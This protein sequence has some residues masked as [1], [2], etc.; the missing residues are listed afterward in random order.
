MLTDPAKAGAEATPPKQNEPTPQSPAKSGRLGRIIAF[1]ALGLVA[2]IIVAVAIFV[3]LPPPS[4]LTP[5]IV[6][7]VA[8]Q[9]GRELKVGTAS[10]GF[11]PDFVL[12]FENVALSNPPGMSG[13]DLLKADA[14]DVRI[15]L[16]SLVKGPLTVS[17]V[18]IK[19]PV[20]TLHKDASGKENWALPRQNQNVRL[21][22]L[23]LQTGTLAYQD[24]QAGQSL[25]ITNVDVAL[26]QK[27]AAME[28]KV[29]G[30][31]VWRAEPIKLNITLGDVQALAGG[32]AT[33]IAA[34]VSSKHVNGTLTGNVS[35]ADKGRLQ[36]S[37][38]ANTPSP[39]DLAHWA[40]SAPPAGL[41][42][43]AASL[44][45]QID[46][47]PNVVALQKTQLTLNGANSTWD[48]RL[49]LTKK[50]TL[51]GTIDAPVLDLTALSGAR[52]APASL[53]PTAEPS[54]QVVPAYEALAA[55]L[56]KLDRELG[57]APPGLAPEAQAA[58]APSVWSNDVVDLAGLSAVD[59][60][61]KA[62]AGR[63][64]FGKLDA[65]GG[66]MAVA[67]KDGKLDLAVQQLQVDKGRMTG[68][69]QLQ[70]AQ[71][72]QPAQTAITIGA[73]NV[74]VETVL[75]EFLPSVPLTGATKLDLTASGK[76]RT[77]RDLVGSLVGKA[78]FSING[79]AIVGI[80]LRSIILSFG[81]WSYNPAHKT[82]FS[83]LQG[84]YDIRQGDLRSVSDL[85]FRG[86]DVDISSSGNINLANGTLNQNVKLQLT[87]PPTHQPIP[88]TV[89]GSLSKPTVKFDFFEYFFGHPGKVGSPSQVA[90][91]PEPMPADLKQRVQGMLN[92]NANNPKLTPETRAALQSLLAAPAE[93]PK[94]GKN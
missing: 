12:H 19:R 82:E 70:G 83:V 59:I 31:T 29:S 39:N 76:G 3:A 37:F 42:L 23:S 89:G 14:L 69:V 61:V 40:G 77:Q 93:K 52:A 60:D 7:S 63:V 10:Y 53:A 8:S 2:L 11:R 43:G 79:G 78:S 50:P 85:A 62:Q 64:H 74:P 18:T 68:R 38:T 24:E 49:D 44:A 67:V 92:A 65:T 5:I 81:H 51:T 28:A 80:D 46:A 4:V 66:V 1:S 30:A 90:L 25:Q 9:T 34:D 58:S 36:G 32:A 72:S 47:T 57:S 88:I 20:V 26:S 48:V 86:K 87:P 45:G 6:K 94:D 73:D 13:P 33:S 21:G 56:D 41:K 55:D 71:A 17:D 91:S 16:V 27:A 75:K 54:L 15:D 84:N 35:P 22:Q